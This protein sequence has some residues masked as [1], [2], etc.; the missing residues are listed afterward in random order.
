MKRI[1]IALS[2]I[3]L[4]AGCGMFDRGNYEKNRG[5]FVIQDD[6]IVHYHTNSIGEIDVF[7]IDQ[8]FTFFEALEYTSFDLDSLDDHAT[9]ASVVSVAEL[10][11]CGVTRD[12]P[13]PRFLRIGDA[14]YYYNVRDNG[15]CTY[16]EYVFHEDGFTDLVAYDPEDVSPIE[17]T[18]VLRFRDTDFK[19]N[20]FDDI[21]FI[22]TI[23]YNSVN[24]QWEKDI[25]SVLPMSLSQAGNAYEEASETLD[26]IRV[27]QLYVLE[28]QSINLLELREDYQDED[29]NNIWAEATVE[30]L[31][32]DHEVIKQVRLKNAG[33]ILDIIAD[34]L[35]R[36][37]MF[38]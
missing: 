7:L 34:T 6:L 30:A 13:I 19:I 25:V 22:E 32:R 16:D 8:L 20:T 3:V 5:G 2:M 28:N 9:T 27:L 24:E 31:G 36:L 37:G 29:V 21:L 1:M 14:T 11:S 33:A 12:D 18:N 15:Y 35:S 10:S 23:S 4:L 17:P 38:A 26:E